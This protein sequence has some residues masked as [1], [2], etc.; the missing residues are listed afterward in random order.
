MS[1]MVEAIISRVGL[2][3]ERERESVLSY[4]RR[5]LPNQCVTIL[6][7]FSVWSNLCSLTILS[8][9]RKHRRILKQAEE[10]NKKRTL[11]R[12]HRMHTTPLLEAKFERIK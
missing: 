3:K 5:D 9:S 4:Y 11:Y 12:L 7:S 1:S 2:Q 8:N 6:L 10:L